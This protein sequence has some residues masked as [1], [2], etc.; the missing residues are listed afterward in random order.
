MRTDFDVHWD[1]LAEE[2]LSGMKEWRLQHPKATLREI[3]GALDARLGKMRAR[4]LQD[5]ALAS[6]AADI[7]AA[8]ETE[9]PLCPACG[10]VL[11]ERTVAAR[12]LV[13]QHN[14]VLQLER[15]YGVCPTCET[16]LFPLDDELELLPGALT[17]SLQEDLVHPSLRSG[18]VLGTW[19]PFGKAAEQLRR[20][21]QTDVSR[22]TAA[23]V[24]EAAGAAY[25]AWQ[26]AE[27]ARIEREL[28]APPAGPAQLFMSVDGAMVPLVGG[29]WAAVKTL[30][31]G[32]VQPPQVVKGETV[33][34]TAEHS[35]FS[36][37]SDSDTFQR[38]ALVETQRRGVET[39]GA[40]GLVTAGAEWCQKFA[41]HHRA[42]AVR[43]LDLPHAGEHLA[44]V[45]QASFGAGS[46][47]MQSWLTTQ[48]HTL[49]HAGPA[50]VVAEVARLVADHSETPELAGHLAYLEKRT[51]Q[52]QYPT[53][54]A[55]G[56]PLGDGA[57]ESAN[58][59]VVEARLKGSGMHWARPHVDP[60]VALRNVVCSDRWD[61]A[62][63][64]IVRT[65]RQQAQQRRDERR[66]QRRPAP[67]PPPAPATAAQP[68]APPPSPAPPVA[69]ASRPAAG[70]LSSAPV[71]APPRQPSHPP[72][73]APAAQPGAPPPSPAPPVAQASR[74]AAG[75][76]S[77]APVQAPPRQ[78]SH[79]PAPAPAAQPG[80]PPPVAQTSS[81]ADEAIN[82]APA[83]APPRQPWRPPADHPWRRLPIGRARFRPPAK[84]AD[85]KT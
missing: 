85:A 7:K 80:A 12:E 45:G 59:L 34:R 83:Q 75:A 56:W 5:A 65:L 15:S 78:P 84:P 40:V 21:R 66:H 77:S 39:A 29:E 3:E 41:D 23:R 44:A 20:F 9:Q 57:V 27:V 2:V 54:R 60:L 81:P 35:Y 67:A 37:L 14:Q 18:Q 49:K 70:A 64:Q 76:L 8:Q 71:Q 73:P 36:R 53:F 32:A 10:R 38:L 13:T 68:G 51:A 46:A 61:E 24:T 26:T 69:Q 11:I 22:P 79:P 31:L 19:L 17:P 43:I 72:A 16:G 30:V 62:W 6:A 48:M 4:M 1:E 58:K 82:S 28:P 42:D 47:E 63:P 25:V 50:D 55:A 52:M 74:P 33:I